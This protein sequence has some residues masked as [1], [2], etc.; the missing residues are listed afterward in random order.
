[1]ISV[2]ILEIEKNK[3]QLFFEKYS[4]Q[5]SPN[6][7]TLGKNSTPLYYHDLLR[8][9]KDMIDLLGYQ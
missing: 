1:M 5:E 4:E 9:K 2:S 7:S 6:K 3:L 8:R